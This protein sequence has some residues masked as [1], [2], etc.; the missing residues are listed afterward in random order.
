MQHGYLD[1]Q[2][3]NLEQP[4]VYPFFWCCVFLLLL[5]HSVDCVLTERIIY[6][7]WQKETFPVAQ[8]SIKLIGIHGTLWLS[9]LFIYL[10]VYCSILMKEKY[11]VRAAVALIT[12]MYWTAMFDWLFVLQ[13]LNFP[14][15]QSL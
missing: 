13:I 15:E 8:L 9:R 14:W 2:L 6:D 7:D 10:F 12:V 11:Y 3:K 4:P 5:I 1:M